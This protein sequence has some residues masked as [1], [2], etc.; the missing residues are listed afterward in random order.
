[1][2]QP[3]E[4]QQ[5]APLRSVERGSMEQSCFCWCRLPNIQLPGPLAKRP[6]HPTC[7]KYE[8]LDEKSSALYKS[9]LL[10][11]SFKQNGNVIIIHQ[12]LFR[13]GIAD[14]GGINACR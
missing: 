14:K 1:M 9:M 3:T 11:Q 5:Q 8:N 12:L 4:V 6:P 2:V 13:G 7:R 10:S